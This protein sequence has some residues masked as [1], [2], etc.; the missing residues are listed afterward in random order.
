MDSN[1]LLEALENLKE[2]NEYLDKLKKITNKTPK[3]KP[4]E[5]ADDES[6]REGSDNTSS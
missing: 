3:E 1:K 6:T 5:E 4:E 2:A